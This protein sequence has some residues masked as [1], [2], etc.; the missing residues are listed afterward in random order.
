VTGVEAEDVIVY[1]FLAASNLAFAKA[2]I[3]EA[4]AR[5][6]LANRF[7]AERVEENLEVGRYM[8]GQSTAITS[9]VTATVVSLATVIQRGDPTLSLVVIAVVSLVQI[10]I[11]S[12]V[13]KRPVSSTG[14]LVP[15]CST[16]WVLAQLGLYVF[17]RSVS[18]G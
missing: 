8:C 5:P 18:A 6:K 1:L 13:V 12:W 11:I 3:A 2:G 9:G 7:T 10:G 16:G 4:V 17:V 14:W 15:I